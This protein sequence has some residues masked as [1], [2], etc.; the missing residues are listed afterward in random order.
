MDFLQNIVIPPSSENIL[1]LKYIQIL[2]YL[3]FLPFTGMII[4][5]TLISV[6]AAETGTKSGD[7]FNLRFAKDVINKLAVNR[8][9]ALGLVILPLISLIFIYAQFLYGLDL[10]TVVMMII[11]LFIFILGFR[12]V[13]R[14][15]DSVEY[16]AVTDSFRFNNI[17]SGKR[18]VIY[19]LIALLLFTSGTSLAANPQNWEN[20]NNFFFLLFSYSTWINFLDLVSA[21]FVVSCGAILFMFFSWQGGIGNITE[22]YRIFIKSRIV[23]ISII[24]AALWIFFMLLKF[25]SAPQASMS[26]SVFV[27]SFL[28][29][30]S[31]LLLCNLFYA[32]QKYKNIKH[33]PMLFIFVLFTLALTILNDQF[34]LANSLKGHFTV[35]NDESLSLQKEK[36][37][38]TVVTTEINAEEIYNLK[39]ASCHKF[40]QKLVGPPH[41]EVIPKYKGDKEKLSAFIQN[42]TKVDPAYTPMPN[43]GITKKEADALA[44]YLILKVGK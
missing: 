32:I 16:M 4:G 7:E 21:S 25:L 36:L 11:S 15:K 43:L 17:K 27:F 3:M 22:T 40:D 9:A 10:I 1:I 5:G 13:Y 12:N 14:Y 30:F 29:F 6:Y 31:I 38:K 39:C 37:S 23:N 35:L 18:G 42:P 26:A 2:C 33:I 34:L 20:Y 19:I 44:E 41:K 8:N 28:S 24:S